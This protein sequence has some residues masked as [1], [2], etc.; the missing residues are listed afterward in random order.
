METL[1]FL[2]STL[3]TINVN[4][5]YIFTNEKGKEKKLMFL[6]YYVPGTLYMLLF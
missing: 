2:A 6:A 1:E 5:V 4:I 3:M